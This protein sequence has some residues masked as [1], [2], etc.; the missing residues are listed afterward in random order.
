MPVIPNAAVRALRS[1][2]DARAAG[3]WESAEVVRDGRQA[4]LGNSRIASGTLDALITFCSVSLEESGG[5]ERYAINATG[6]AIANDPKVAG[7]ILA[8][9]L[10]GRPTEI[11]ADGQVRDMEGH[12][13]PYPAPGGR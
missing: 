8:R 6:I 3:D 2:R 13:A 7:D 10:A 12:P 1:M 4:W 9:V 5:I 11:G